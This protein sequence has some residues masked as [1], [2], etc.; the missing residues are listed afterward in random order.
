[1][2]LPRVETPETFQL[3]KILFVLSIV[4]LQYPKLGVVQLL[5][6]R[7]CIGPDGIA[8]LF[9]CSFST[10]LSVWFF[11]EHILIDARG[12]CS[13][14]IDWGLAIKIAGGGFGMV[15]LILIILQVA[16]DVVRVVTEKIAGAKE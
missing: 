5:H 1:L 13:Y 3:G 4:F 2:C 16:I 6:G 7:T 15:F 12:S 11:T 8:S 9:G 14:M 10:F